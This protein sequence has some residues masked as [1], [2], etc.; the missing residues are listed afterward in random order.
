M[1]IDF[2]NTEAIIFKKQYLVI[3]DLHIGI[4]KELLQKGINI[5]AQT[6]SIYSRIK[7]LKAR[8]NVSKLIIT[9]D[10]KHNVPRVSYIELKEVPMLLQKLSN[11]FKKIVITKGNHDGSLEKL[12][13]NPNIIIVREFRVGKVVFLHGHTRPRL[14]G[15]LYI[16]GHHHFAINI[17]SSIGESFY[18]KVFVYGETGEYDFLILPAFSNLVGFWEVGKFHGPLTKDI[19]SYNVLALDGTLL[20]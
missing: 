11:I 19:D 6:Q 12:N 4:E 9:G 1:F 2:T 7:Q 17:K 5:P 3:S 20:L 16:L 14:K 18:E 8:Y 10:F 15:K 13:D